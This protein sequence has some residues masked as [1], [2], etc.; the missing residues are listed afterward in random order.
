MREGGISVYCL[1]VKV[2][3]KMNCIKRL[4]SA[5]KQTVNRNN[6]IKFES[7]CFYIGPNISIRLSA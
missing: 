6:L 1:K 7:R 5:E 2:S 3:F 4:E